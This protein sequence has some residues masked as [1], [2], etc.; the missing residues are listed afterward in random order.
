VQLMSRAACSERDENDARLTRR[1]K[2]IDIL[3]TV[4]GE[5]AD[6]IA[7]LQRTEIRPDPRAL[8]GPPIQFPISELPARGNVNQRDRVGTKPSALSE[9]V[10]GNH[11]LSTGCLEID[12]AAA[13]PRGESDPSICSM[14]LVNSRGRS[15]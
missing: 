6:A 11:E 14:I 9:D 3:D 10:A 13:D 5:N 12:C 8:Q 1:P 4:L 7:W 15:N 2:G